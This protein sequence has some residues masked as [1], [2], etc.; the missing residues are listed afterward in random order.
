MISNE[1]FQMLDESKIVPIAIKKDSDLYKD[2]GMDSLSFIR[3][4]L[5]V[6]ERYSISFDILEMELCLKVDNLISI[7]KDKLKE[8]STNND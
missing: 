2:L 7:V 1:I 5:K 8:V 6:E 3:F 4:L